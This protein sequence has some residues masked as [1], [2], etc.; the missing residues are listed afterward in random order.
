[1]RSEYSHA[2]CAP[3]RVK[4]LYRRDD[5]D[6]VCEYPKTRNWIHV[7]KATWYLTASFM[8]NHLRKNTQLQAQR[9]AAQS[10]PQ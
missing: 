10:V 1:M 3:H 4:H 8:E 9:A 7:G 6:L 5:T 2:F